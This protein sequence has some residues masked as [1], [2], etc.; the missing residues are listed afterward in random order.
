MYASATKP[1]S[2]EAMNIGII[3]LTASKVRN[4]AGCC[5]NSLL[6]NTPNTRNPYAESTSQATRAGTAIRRRVIGTPFWKDPPSPLGGYGG[7]RLLSWSG[8]ESA[9]KPRRVL[10]NSDGGRRRRGRELAGDGGLALRPHLSVAQ[11]HLPPG[12]A[13]APAL[14]HAAIDQRPPVEVVIHVAG[15]DE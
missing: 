5:A 15:E 6:S 8:L 10:M 11:K 9:T 12:S 2:D 4:T 1:T 14:E 13:L 3:A 7:S